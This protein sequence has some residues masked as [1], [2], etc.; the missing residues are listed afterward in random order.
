[1]EKDEL[2]VM[3]EMPEW[4]LQK[5]EYIP[6]S[7]REAFLTKSTKAVLGVLS[8]MKFQGGKDGRF[9]ATPSFQ[10]F[11]TLIYIILTACNQNYFFTLIMFA[12][13][14]VVLAFYPAKSIRR[15]LAGTLGAVVISALILTPA[16]FMGNPQILLRITTKVYISVTLIGILSYGTSWNRLTAALRTFRVPDLLIFTLDITLKY[17]SVLGGI[18]LDI[19]TALKLRSVGKN[20]EKARSF[21]GILG[22]SFLKSREMSD[23]M[24]ASMCCRGFTGEYHKKHKYRFRK[25]DLLHLLLLVC[26][27]RLFILRAHDYLNSGCVMQMLIF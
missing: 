5:E 27:L 8:R 22:T 26:C 9:S 4:M 16:M 24:Y 17:I 6:S 3:Q 10:L 18:S 1:M 2:N 20:P 13:V 25:Q 12:G 15:I 7:D 21:S 19:L 11:Y 14:M 23:E